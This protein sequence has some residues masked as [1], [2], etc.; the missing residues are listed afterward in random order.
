ME[1]AIMNNQLAIILK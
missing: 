1:N